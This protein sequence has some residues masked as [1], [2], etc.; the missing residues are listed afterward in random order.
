MSTFGK[1]FVSMIAVSAF[2]SIGAVCH[3]ED[4]SNAND[5]AT[6]GKFDQ[7][8]QGDALGGLERTAG[9]TTDQVDVPPASAPQPVD[10]SSD[11][12]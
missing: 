6:W 7:G 4:N 3:A 12:K 1:T 2:L 9:K 8:Q 5:N 11:G 10:T